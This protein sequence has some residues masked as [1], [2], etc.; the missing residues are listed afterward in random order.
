MTDL[1]LTIH[2]GAPAM[3]I[4]GAVERYNAFVEFTKAIMKPG[5][6]FGVIPGT[7]KPTLLKPGAEKLC[8]FFGFAPVF[9]DI[10]S[11]TNWETGFFFYR[12]RCDLVRNGQVVASGIG[13]CN[14]KE[15]KYR[16]RNSERVCPSCGKPT[17]IKGKAEYGGGYICFAKKGG[18]GAKFTDDDQSIIGQVVG[19][20]EN[21]ETFDLVNTIDKMAQKRALVAATLIGANASE[22]YTQDIEDLDTVEGVYHE[23]K[24]PPP[25]MTLE[26]AKA[27][28]D[29]KGIP[30]EE[31]TTLALTAISTNEKFSD[32]QRLAAKLNLES[33][34]ETQPA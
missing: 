23:V 33:R 34:A 18:C 26:Q 17:I 2:E 32:K 7:P 30:Y 6:D 15:K 5:K 3:S 21:T 11:V 10:G 19:Q 8:T 25:V 14:T 24:T 22:F 29:S 16:W 4:Q 9:V 27:F 31:K 12:Y 13:S 20:I 28:T 1:S